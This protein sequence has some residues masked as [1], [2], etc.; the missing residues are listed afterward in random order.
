MKNGKFFLAL[1]LGIALMALPC[2]AQEAAVTTEEVVAEAPAVEVPV[3][4]EEAAVAV[5]E[6]A[7]V[8]EEAEVV[9][10]QIEEVSGEVV[11]F[12]AE[13]SNLVL[14]YVVD[15]EMNI[16]KEESFDVSA[17]TDIKKGEAVIAFS[18]IQAGDM[19]T[20]KCVIDA[21]GNK[22]VASVTVQ[23]SVVEEAAEEVIEEP[24]LEPV[25]E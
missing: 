4:A 11:S 23:E 15:A 19:A 2:M 8:A 22:T 21:D 24:V 17:T 7:P 18:D 16:E 3:V 9:A 25:A 12:D 13:N 1:V 10:E 6:A 14:K 20:V 5:E